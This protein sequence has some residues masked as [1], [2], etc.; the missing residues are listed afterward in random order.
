VVEIVVASEETVE[1]V[2]SVEVAAEVEA[3]WSQPNSGGKLFIDYLTS[4]T[5]TDNLLQQWH[6]SSA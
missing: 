6:I 4:E 5:H 2:V 1:E 3:T